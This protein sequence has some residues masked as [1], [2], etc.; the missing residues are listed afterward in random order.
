MTHWDIFNN[1][2]KF[3]FSFFNMAQC[4]ICSQVWRLYHVVAQQLQRAHSPAVI[5]YPSRQNARLSDT[6]DLR[7]DDVNDNATNQ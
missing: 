6:R 5:G 7:F 2:T 3:E 1:A 4:V